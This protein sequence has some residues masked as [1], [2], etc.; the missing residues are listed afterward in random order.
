VAFSAPI[1][2]APAKRYTKITLAA[3]EAN[4]K[5]F[6]G[7]AVE[8]VVGIMGPVN[9]T[10]IP[11]LTPE[12]HA[13]CYLVDEQGSART[14][15]FFRHGTAI[16][17]TVDASS[18]SGSGAPHDLFTARG[19]VRVTPSYPQRALL[20]DTIEPADRTFP[21]AERPSGRDWYVRA[22]ESQGDGSR[23]HPFRDPFQ[24]LEKAG[25]GDRINVSEGDYGGKLKSGK[26]VVDKPWLALLGGWNRDFTTR[27]PW[28]TPTV[29]QWPA[30]SKTRGQGALLEGSGD[31]TGLLVDGFVFD[32]RTL[33]AYD[34]DGFLDPGHSDDA[35]HLWVVSPHSAVRNCT[36]VNG[37]GGA[38]RLSNAV[39]FE[40]NLIANVWH[41][42]IRVTGGFGARPALIR[43]N[44]VLFVFERRF[45]DPSTSSGVGIVLE[46]FAGAQLEGNVFQ[47]IDN[48]AVKA[49]A[50]LGEIELVNNSF[51]RNFTV[52]QSGQGMPPPTIDEKNL[53]LLNDL[54]FKRQ[55]GN[56]V[57]DGEFEF[58]PGAY[59][60][61]LKRTSAATTRFTEAEWNAIAR[62]TPATTAVKPGIGVALDARTVALWVP[63]N[64]QARGARPR[65]N[66]KAR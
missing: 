59:A 18:N 32:R 54:P 20:L 30:D 55:T 65:L 37:A 49:N 60:S 46:P 45:H 39:T 41:T 44:T 56:Q 7:Q 64:A 19:T 13:G 63:K 2:A 43:N 23:E 51:F 14:P 24:A 25:A 57:L 4:A 36:F 1:A 34:A 10:G 8:V 15:A 58:D 48:I 27:D 40:N 9:P 35:E 50:R 61:W 6:D 62:P 5:S 38:V 3:L 33:N 28:R 21:T 53:T 31:H 22:G 17:R 29:L 42:A 16:E 11:G 52:F 66:E 47:Y 12:T 26:W